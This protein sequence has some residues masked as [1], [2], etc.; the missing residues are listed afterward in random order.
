M[1]YVLP[2]FRISGYDLSSLR[3]QDFMKW[4]TLSPGSGFQ[5]KFYVFPGFRISGHNFSSLCV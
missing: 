1:V 4:F 2:G 3:V 5:D